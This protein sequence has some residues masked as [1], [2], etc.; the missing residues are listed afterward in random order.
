MQNFR[1]Y[2]EILGVT[3]DTTVEQL[4]KSYRQLARRYHPDL[5]PGDKAAEE[6]FKAISEA[7]EIL[8]D[9]DKRFQYDQYKRYWQ[10]KGGRK[11][12]RKTN[13]NGA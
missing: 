10:Q 5:N 8:S 1:N 11:S 2:Y 6:T 7:Y 3:Q 13:G 12:P 4:K 9:E